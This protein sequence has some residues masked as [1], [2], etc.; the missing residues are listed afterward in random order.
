MND[1]TIKELSGLL[2]E[3]Q[4]KLTDLQKMYNDLQ[5]KYVA[6][7]DDKSESIDTSVRKSRIQIIKK[8]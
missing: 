1:A 7:N 8:H 5:E 3:Y 2:I 6:I 4:K